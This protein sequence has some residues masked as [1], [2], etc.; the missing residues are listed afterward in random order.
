MIDIKA[1]EEDFL[2]TFEYSIKVKEAHPNK[3]D[4]PYMVKYLSSYY[5]GG[6]A[7]FFKDLF[8]EHSYAVTL[9]RENGE[10]GLAGLLYHSHNEWSF[11][12]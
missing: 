4:F 7:V 12:T 3:C 10:V 5:E 11:N 8:T 9:F 1:C 2:K 6:K